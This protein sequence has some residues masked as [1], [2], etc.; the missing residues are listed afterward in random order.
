MAPLKYR[1]LFSYV[2]YDKPKNKAALL[3]VFLNNL[4]EPVKLN[5]VLIPFTMTATYGDG[6][7]ALLGLLSHTTEK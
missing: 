4:F 3:L 7:T 1:A 2:G 5:W 6:W